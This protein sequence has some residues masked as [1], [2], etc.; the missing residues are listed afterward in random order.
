MGFQSFRLRKVCKSLGLKK[1][2]AARPGE[3][4]S[5]SNRAKQQNFFFDLQLLQL[6]ALLPFDLQRPTV[7]L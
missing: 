1:N 4:K 3:D 7:T 6:V 5:G 2:S